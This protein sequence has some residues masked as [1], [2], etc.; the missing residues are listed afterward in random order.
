VYFFP[1]TGRVLVKKLTHLN[2][3]TLKRREQE[4]AARLVE[5]PV[6]GDIELFS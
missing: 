5:E 6:S 2:N 1:G 3:D 4:Y